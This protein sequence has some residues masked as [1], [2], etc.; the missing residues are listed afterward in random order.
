MAKIRHRIFEMYEFRDE[1]V[2]SLTPRIVRLREAKPLESWPIK[3]LAISQLASVSL[4]EF[5]TSRI[6][7]DDT[8][9]ELREVLL[10]LEDRL[11]NDSK[12]LFDFSGVVG[13]S[14]ASIDALAQFNQHLR[15]KGSRIALCCISSDLRPSFFSTSDGRENR[16]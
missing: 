1:A 6:V 11:T 16:N 4:V 15:L 3:H 2:D 7:G 14:A 5:T 12:V 9:K 8:E 13:V 10:Q